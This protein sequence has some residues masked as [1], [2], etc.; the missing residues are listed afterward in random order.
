MKHEAWHVADFY[1]YFFYTTS[2]LKEPGPCPCVPYQHNEQPAP[3]FASFA[4]CL[5]AHAL[6]MQAEIR[7]DPEDGKALPRASKSSF[8]AGSDIR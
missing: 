8:S 2:G 5:E 7:I 1:F 6:T 3:Y 4:S